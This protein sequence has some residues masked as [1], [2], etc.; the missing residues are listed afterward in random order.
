MGQE[1]NCK[2]IN[3]YNKIEFINILLYLII[4]RIIF[5]RYLFLHIVIPNVLDHIVFDPIINWVGDHVTGEVPV[6]C[7]TNATVDNIVTDGV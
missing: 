5:L 4:G 2:T 7:D 1:F 6:V 3:N